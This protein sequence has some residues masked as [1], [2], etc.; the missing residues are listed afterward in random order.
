[1]SNPKYKEELW[2]AILGQ[3]IYFL[4]FCCNLIIILMRT[5]GDCETTGTVQRY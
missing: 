2:C 3:R 1:M 5:E 4:P